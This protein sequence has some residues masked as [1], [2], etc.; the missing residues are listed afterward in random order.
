MPASKSG[1]RATTLHL[2]LAVA[3]P[4]KMIKEIKK[5]RENEGA[6]VR[7]PAVPADA[8]PTAAEDKV[9]ATAEVPVVEPTNNYVHYNND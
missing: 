7:D 9:P 5:V 1:P 6:E 8:H 2:L 4:Q 3:L